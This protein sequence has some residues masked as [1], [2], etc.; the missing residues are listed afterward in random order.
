MNLKV[1]LESICIEGEALYSIFIVIS[2]IYILN[3]SSSW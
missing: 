2:F 1:I 3:C